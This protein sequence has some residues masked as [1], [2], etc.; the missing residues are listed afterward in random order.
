MYLFTIQYKL[1]GDAR[2]HSR[3][4]RA[5]T[6]PIALEMFNETITAGSLSGEHPEIIKVIKSTPSNL[7][8]NPQ[9]TA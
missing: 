7:K 9:N 5:I 1:V 3:H 6:E 8:K 4:Y 2:L